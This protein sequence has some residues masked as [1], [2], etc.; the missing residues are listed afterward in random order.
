MFDLVSLENTRFSPRSLN[1]SSV[2]VDSI[3]QQNPAKEVSILHGKLKYEV[4]MLTDQL[5]AAPKAYAFPLSL[6]I[7]HGNCRARQRLWLY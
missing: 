3:Q 4:L 6:P 1:M 5:R 7:S 2:I